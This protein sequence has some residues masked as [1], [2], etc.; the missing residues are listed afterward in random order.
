MFFSVIIPSYNREHILP[1][2]IDSVLQQTFPAFELIIVDNG[3]TDNTRQLIEIYS[4]QDSRIRYLWQENSGSPAGSRNTGIKNAAGEWIAFLDSDDWWF[5]SKLEEVYKTIQKDQT[6]SY[7]GIS[8]WEDKYV[9]NHPHSIL[10]HGCE[11]ETGLYKKLLFRGNLFS[12]SAMTVKTDII[13]KIGGFNPQ[14]DYFIVEDY[15]LWMRIAQQG[16]IVS[17]KKSLGVFSINNSNMSGNIE[18]THKNL[19]Q[20]INDHIKNLAVP[21]EEKEQLKRIHCARIDYYQGR[22]YQLDGQF[23][24]AVPLLW[25]SI[26]QHPWGLKK[27]LSLALSIVRI[28]R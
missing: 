26:R 24:K 4:R 20:L 5:P 15:D 23:S 8:H 1:K 22:T 21:L 16:S 11:E 14:K 18:L 27:W 25:S 19:K 12:T 2:A 17:I 3:S 28:A 6:N 10:R 13:R 7:V 9:N